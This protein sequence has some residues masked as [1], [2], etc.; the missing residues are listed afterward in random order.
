MTR[1]RHH[2]PAPSTDL[3]IT[4]SQ[5]EA[6]TILAGTAAHFASIT[7]RGATRAQVDAAEALDLGPWCRR[8]PHRRGVWHVAQPVPSGAFI[9]AVRGEA[10]RV[11]VEHHAARAVDILADAL[12]TR[13]Q[14]SL[15]F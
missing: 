14:R 13:R 6:Y 9:A 1:P 8:D 12:D 10:D 2:V 15:D 5:A 11:S 4:A 7:L 3:R